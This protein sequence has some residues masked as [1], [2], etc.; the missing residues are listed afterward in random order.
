MS[1]L[2]P[3]SVPPESP[4]SP[5]LTTESVCGL[6]LVM[7]FGATVTRRARRT[8]HARR[9]GRSPLRRASVRVLVDDIPGAFADVVLAARIEALTIVTPWITDGA[10]GCEAFG[11]IFDW[12]VTCDARITL[13]TRAPHNN[14]PHLRAIQALLSTGGRVFLNPDLH[15]KIFVAEFVS[16]SRAA[17]VGSSNLTA[18]SSDLLETALLVVSPPGP[19]GPDLVSDLLSGPVQRFS[20]HSESRQIRDLSAIL[21]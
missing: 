12:S 15:A 10:G 8:R 16:G 3:A 9:V 4:I 6:L 1:A 5:L 13:I 20:R 7:N 18:G 2:A 14:E 17:V 19:H 11:R 21:P